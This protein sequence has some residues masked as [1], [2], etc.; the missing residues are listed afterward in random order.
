MP[1]VNSNNAYLISQ[2]YRTFIE[3]YKE[4]ACKIMMDRGAANIE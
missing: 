3:V 1:A 4:I 2:G